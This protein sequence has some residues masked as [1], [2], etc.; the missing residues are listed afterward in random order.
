MRVALTFDTEH[1]GR[2][3]PAGVEEHLLDILGRAGVRATF[4]LQGRWVRSTPETARR[5]APVEGSVVVTSRL[6]AK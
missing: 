1:P 3:C 4:F 2:P 6:L 5:I